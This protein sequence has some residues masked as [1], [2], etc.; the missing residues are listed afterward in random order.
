MMPSSGAE[1][2]IKRLAQLQSIR[3]PHERIWRQ[4]AEV[5]A[6]DSGD[7]LLTGL[8]TQTHGIQSAYPMA[9]HR[10]KKIYDNTA[11]VAVDRLAS[12]IEAMVV[13]QAAYW[14]DL[15]VQDFAHEA[16]TDEEKRW[17]E[18]LRNLMFRV[19]YDSDT[20]WHASIQTCMRRVVAFGNAFMYVEEGD[21]DKSLIRYRALP[22]EE[23]FVAD[24]H[25]GQIDT[26]YRT[27]SL[28]ARQAAQ[29]FG[30]KCPDRILQA[31]ADP[32]QQD[33]LFQF[34]HAIGPR[35]DWGRA[36][37][38][39]GARYYSVH[40]SLEERT[41]VQESGFYEFPIIDFRWLPEPGRV[42]GEGPVQKVLADIQT[43]NLMAKN[44]LRA[45]QQAVDP[46]LLVADAGIM[47]RPNTN[48]GK[49]NFGGLSP[50]GQK[51]IEPLYT[52]TRLDFA[53][54]LRMAKAGQIKEG[55]YIN[56]FAVL[57]QNPQMT[58]TEALIKAN[59]KSDL[60]GPAGG[61][62]QQSL[63]NMIER[64][65]GILARAGAFAQD[66]AYRVPR[67]LQ[68][69]SI[70]AQFTSPL[71]RL[72]R[73]SE[74]TGTVR[75]LEILNPIMAIDPTVVDH[76]DTDE[77][78]RGLSDVLG[79]PA[80]FVRPLDAVMKIRADREEQAAMAAQ[81]QAAKDFAQAGKLGSDALA[82]MGAAGM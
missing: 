11:V 78:V 77:A 53:T 26:F 31:A 68:D 47:N 33:K 59:E 65:I 24:N 15:G 45:S 58:A 37:G 6:P 7:F 3:A 39:L 75:L 69:K 56:L 76:L 27:Y 54:Q 14:H 41:I 66:S 40:V 64:E 55:L 34:I 79:V 36:P 51:L 4:V 1:D 25:L 23:C 49:I 63:S 74:A 35:Q 21:G 29:K 67:S 60:L 43:L 16:T 61:R 46:P 17:L 32:V 62:L 13:P 71:D 9:S 48:P 82:N 8:N 10:S 20:G 57:T 73:S 81:A 50:S 44:E 28:T 5:A 72:R 80:K 2:V 30:A 38:V 18:R 70:G 12:G 42:Y 52:G 19:R 22:L